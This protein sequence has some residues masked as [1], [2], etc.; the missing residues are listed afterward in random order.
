MGEGK[1][2]QLFQ[3]HVQRSKRR[4]SVAMVAILCFIGGAVLAVKCFDEIP[5]AIAAMQTDADWAR[6]KGYLPENG[7]PEHEITQ[8]NF[9]KMVVTEYAAKEPGITV[10]AGAENHWAAGYYATAK[11]EGLIDC[12]CIISPERAVTTDEAAKFVMLGVNSKAQQR[13]LALDEVKGWLTE[14]SADQRI[15]YQD[16]IVLVR[17]MGEI[18]DDKKLR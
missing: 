12:T 1:R 10:P 9:L 14:K 5:A 16:A 13:V 11:Q 7:K 18:L 2:K 3:G 15:T 17:K 4:V 8:A 6:A